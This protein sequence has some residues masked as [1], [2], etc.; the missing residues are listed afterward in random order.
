LCNVWQWFCK[1]GD[2]L[3]SVLE[4]L[5]FVQIQ[6]EKMN[7]EL[8]NKKDKNVQIGEKKYYLRTFS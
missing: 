2:E 4:I 7:I 1:L 8:E 3:E 6:P 5:L